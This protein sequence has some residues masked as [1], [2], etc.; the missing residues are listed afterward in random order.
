MFLGRKIKEIVYWFKRFYNVVKMVNLIR[1]LLFRFK[2]GLIEFL[3]DLKILFVLV[4]S[5]LIYLRYFKLVVL[6]LG[7]LFCIKFKRDNVVVVSF[8]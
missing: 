1:F 3:L 6:E 7:R 2:S 5:F 4:L 8:D